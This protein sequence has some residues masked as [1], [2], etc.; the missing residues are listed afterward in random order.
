MSQFYLIDGAALGPEYFGFTDPLT[1]TWK[2]KK[3]NHRT[4]LYGVTWSTALVG[5]ASGFQDPGLAADGFD[6]EVGT[7]N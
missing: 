6:G 7:S 3:Y 1:N 2:P 5:D 4:D